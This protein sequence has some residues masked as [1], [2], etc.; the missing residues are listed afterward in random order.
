MKSDQIESIVVRYN[1]L[2]S[3]AIDVINTIAY[4]KI[5][6]ELKQQMNKDTVLIFV[7]AK[8]ITYKTEIGIGLNLPNLS[9]GEA[10]IYYK[11][12]LLQELLTGATDNFMIGQYV[13]EFINAYKKYYKSFASESFILT[14]ALATKDMEAPSTAI[15]VIKQFSK[16]R[17]KAA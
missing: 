16:R 7:N 3:E 6:Q 5:T 8:G 9:I 15:G 10:L 1:K 11:P 13:M 4:K 12:D 2:V 14:T 17:K